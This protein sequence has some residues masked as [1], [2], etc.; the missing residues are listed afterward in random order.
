LVFGEIT[1]WVF[2]EMEVNVVVKLILLWL[3]AIAEADL[4]QSGAPFV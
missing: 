1:N 2:E 4:K 3:K